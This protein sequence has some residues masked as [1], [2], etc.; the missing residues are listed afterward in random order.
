MARAWKSSNDPLCTNTRSEPPIT[1]GN[2]QP[3]YAL[4]VKVRRYMDDTSWRAATESA[5]TGTIADL[6]AVQLQ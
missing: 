1:A 6:N 3:L 4:E 5:R 2:S